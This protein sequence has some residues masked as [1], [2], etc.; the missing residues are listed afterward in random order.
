MTATVWPVR[1]SIIAIVA[2]VAGSP[3]PDGLSL[4]T[5]TDFT[6]SAPML[7]S[8]AGMKAYQPFTSASATAVR[9]GITADPDA[10]SPKARSRISIIVP[11]SS[12]PMIVCLSKR[13]AIIPNA[14]C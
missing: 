5:V 7:L 9:C 13:S 3:W 6:P 1:L 11:I 4:Y 8:C 10:S 12:R 14:S 2:S